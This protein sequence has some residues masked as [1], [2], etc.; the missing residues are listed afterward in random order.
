MADYN[1]DNAQG[2]WTRR[3]RK[4]LSHKKMGFDGGSVKLLER[5]IGK[6]A[7]IARRG[8]QGDDDSK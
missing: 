8:D 4:K 2:K 7:D 5:I 3:D 1:A 6:K